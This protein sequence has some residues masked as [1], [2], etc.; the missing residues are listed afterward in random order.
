M[1]SVVFYCEFVIIKLRK[2]KNRSFFKKNFFN[3]KNKILNYKTKM[4]KGL[5]KKICGKELIMDLL[6]CDP[7]IIRSKKKILQYSKK[8]SIFP[9]NFSEEK[10]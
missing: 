5:R 7:K 8:P 1:C 6:D 3:R 2:E 4:P 10:N 9:E